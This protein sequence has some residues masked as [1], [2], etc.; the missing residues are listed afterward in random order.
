MR[1][2]EKLPNVQSRK[3]YDDDSDDNTELL[4]AQARA[5]AALAGN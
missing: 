2:F 3:I 1:A 4:A 5:A